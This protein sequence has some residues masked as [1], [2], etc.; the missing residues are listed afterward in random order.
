[1]AAV[2][3]ELEYRLKG[4]RAPLYRWRHRGDAA[5]ECPICG[6]A[7]PFMRKGARLH[8]KCPACG[9]LE[10]ARLMHLVMEQWFARRDTA[11]LDCLHVA[12]EVTL[13]GRLRPRFRRYV[14]ADLYRTDVDFRC[15]V[16]SLPFADGEF[17]VLIASHVL[18]YPEDDRQALREMHRV[19]KP[20]GIAFLPVPIVHEQT[21][22]RVT[23]DP[24]TRM[25]HE[26]GLD[27]FDRMRAVFAQVELPD[28]ASFDAKYQLYVYRGPD[29]GVPLEVSPGVYRDIIPVCTR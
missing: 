25:M 5:F 17:D 14:T 26:P 7:G 29:A 24:V 27:F 12:P 19:L 18:E 4:L 2:L 3:K 1:M 21:V 6:Y 23:R 28:S 9:E 13:G 10:R 11:T 22:D 20:G 15:D 16:Q 8:A